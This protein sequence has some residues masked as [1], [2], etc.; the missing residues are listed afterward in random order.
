[1]TARTYSSVC[2]KPGMTR[3]SP[4]WIRVALV[5]ISMTGAKYD[6]RTSYATRSRM[7]AKVPAS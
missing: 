5:S 4:S 2:S 6:G 3:I 7:V 1:M